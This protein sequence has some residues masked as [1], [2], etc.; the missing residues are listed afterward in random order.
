M[1]VL[2]FVGGGDRADMLSKRC[3]DRAP[4][5][6]K[7][8]GIEGLL[9]EPAQRI[10]ATHQ[11]IALHVHPKCQNHVDDDGRAKRE[12]GDVD[13][14]HPDARSSK[15]HAFPNRA[16]HTKGA[17]FNGRFPKAET[18]IHLRKAAKI[19]YGCC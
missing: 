18:S 5:Y 16:A 7:E 11:C 1:R 13:K 17:P 12:E 3:A 15:A 6:S 4:D 9:S 19:Q 2:S 8:I 14:P 10:A